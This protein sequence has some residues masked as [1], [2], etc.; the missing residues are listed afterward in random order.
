MNKATILIIDDNL[1]LLEN[2]AEVLQVNG[3]RVIAAHNGE[4][5][6]KLA[7][8]NRPDLILCDIMMRVIDGYD[9]LSA[10]R[11]DTAA[12]KTPFVFLT[13]RAEKTDIKK[14][15]EAGANAYLVKPYTMDALMS[16]IATT[17]RKIRV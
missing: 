17:L 2:T 3:Y 1:E 8:E 5:G 11:K 4:Q 13:A 7:K 15:L 14:G 12:S 10:I 16:V 6:I 9:V